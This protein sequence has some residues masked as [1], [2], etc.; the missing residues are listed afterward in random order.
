MGAAVVASAV[1]V[2][3]AYLQR[4]RADGKS[5]HELDIPEHLAFTPEGMRWVMPSV[6]SAEGMLAYSRRKQMS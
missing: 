1:G 2:V 3:K 4:V 6:I 5:I